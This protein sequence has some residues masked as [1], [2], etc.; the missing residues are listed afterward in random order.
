MV[1]QCSENQYLWEH[2][3]V[4]MC[5][6]RSN[7]FGARQIVLCKILLKQSCW[8]L[9]NVR[10]LCVLYRVRVRR[11]IITYVA[12]ETCCDKASIMYTRRELVASKE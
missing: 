11:V 3:T 6:E 12:A 2:F 4:Y 9:S 10:Y 7:S 1:Q 5:V 8:T